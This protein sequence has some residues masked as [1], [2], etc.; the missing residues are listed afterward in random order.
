[1]AVIAEMGL[2]KASVARI[3]EHAGLSRAA[4]FECQGAYQLACL[5]EKSRGVRGNVVARTARNRTADL[6]KNR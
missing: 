1:M 2:E 5:R 6:T 4:A 3:A